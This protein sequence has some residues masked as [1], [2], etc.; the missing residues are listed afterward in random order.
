MQA[1]LEGRVITAEG[2][3]A[4]VIGALGAATMPYVALLPWVPRFS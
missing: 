1:A 2:L 4:M 3:N